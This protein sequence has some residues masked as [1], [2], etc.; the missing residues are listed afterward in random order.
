MRGIPG[1][2]PRFHQ[3]RRVAL[4]RWSAFARQTQKPGGELLPHRRLL[5]HPAAAT[6]LNMQDAQILPYRIDLET[7]QMYPLFPE[8]VSPLPL[9]LLPE[10]TGAARLAFATAYSSMVSPSRPTTAKS[11]PPAP[12]FL[13]GSLANWNVLGRSCSARSAVNM[14]LSGSPASSRMHW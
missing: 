10:M 13:Q 9:V 14:R 11:R 6:H 12:S 8:R 3:R 1:I 5:R 4:P 2:S 7:P